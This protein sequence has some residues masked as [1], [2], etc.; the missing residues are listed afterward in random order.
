MMD[1]N[2]QVMMDRS[3]TVDA[4]G[5][6][7]VNVV[8]ENVSSELPF[9]PDVPTLEDVGTFN[10]SNEDEDDDE[11]AD[12]NNLDT[13][14]QVNLTPTTRIHKDHPLDLVIEDLQSATQTRNM[15]KNLEEHGVVFK[16][17]Y[18]RGIVIRNKARLV[19]QSHIQ[20]EEID[21]DE[22]FAH[23]TRIEAIR[24]FLDYAS[25][26]YFVVHQMDIKSAFLYEKIKEEVYVCQPPGLK[27]PNFHDRVYKV[28]KALYGLHQ[29]PRAWYE[30]L[31]RYLLDNGFQRG[32]IDK[33]LFIKRLKMSSVG[34]KMH[35]AFPLLEESSHW[36]YN[37]PLP[38]EGVP[39]ARR[40][41][42]PL[43]KSLHCYDET[44]SQREL[45][46]TLRK[47]IM[48]CP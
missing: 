31:S 12:M 20:E 45:A 43:L 26:K 1:S 33:A 22:V 8:G 34:N 27:D 9:D 7:G 47:W 38:V 48:S 15:T 18:K 19:A 6:N 21:Y 4:A 14:I 10:F 42:I 23:V 28:E 46:V 17:K 37:C 5:T 40:M 36:Q 25:F 35:K 32:K 39:T 13:I 44:A 3:L 16:N 41:E 30:T 24:L 29:A 11:E 2:L